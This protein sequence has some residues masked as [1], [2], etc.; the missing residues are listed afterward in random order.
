MCQSE[1]KALSKIKGGKKTKRSKWGWKLLNTSMALAYLPHE[2]ENCVLHTP[3]ITPV[4]VMR[5]VYGRPVISAPLFI[6]WPKASITKMR[7]QVSIAR[8]F[9][10]SAS[11]S[12]SI[13]YKSVEAGYSVEGVALEVCFVALAACVLPLSYLKA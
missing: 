12:S 9:P 5:D 6:I 8:W 7:K 4:T 10:C 2:W 13:V 1:L 3:K 11:P